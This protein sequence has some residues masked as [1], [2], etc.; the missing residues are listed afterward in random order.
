MHVTKTENSATN[1]TLLINGDATD[2]API[3][4]HVLSHFSNVKVPGFRAGKAPADLIEKHVSQ[5]AL[6]DEFMEHAL[7]DLFRQAVSENQLRPLGQP[8]V[9][10][11][12]FVPYSE[13]EFMA[14][15][16]V[17]G[18]VTLP[19]YKKIKLAKPKVELTAKDVNDVLDSLQKRLA[20]RRAK[21]GAAGNGDEVTI[22]FSGTD[23]DGKPVAGAEGNDYPLVLGSKNFIPGFEENL[24]GCAAGDNK[25]FELTFP[26]D[27]G[28]S[29]LQGK[30]VTFKV[31][32]KL[33]SD[34]IEP[35]IDD[36]FA[37]KVGPFETLADLKDDIK[38][39]VRAEKQLQADQ[40]YENEL[41]KTITDKSKVEV[42]AALV[43]EQIADMETQEKQN[44]VYRGQT[45]DEH[46][47][48]EGISEEQHRER[49][50]PD[51]TQRVKAGLV[52]SEVAQREKVEVTPEEI[53]LRL[54]I[55]KGQYQDPQMQAELDKPENR[56][57][58]EMR[59]LT[60][61]TVEKLVS[62]AS[63]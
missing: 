61:K 25:E 59:L 60:E 35:K 28:V 30:K 27:Y 22:D 38:K 51:A 6:L 34:V 41:I 10:L 63:K 58:V 62:Y 54:Q 50:R 13:L 15:I 1:V 19:D 2:L 37:A 57:D 32:V 5:Q 42:P 55:L 3:K 49:Q 48:Q 11:K 9:Q 47:K 8:D 39:Q 24:I 26:K 43:D 12:K 18:P 4:R 7:N 56:R 31:K 21:E 14:T 16:D 23:G 40:T 46:L 17:L 29:A 45:W 44:L 52:L 33:V 20:E 53:E 36:E